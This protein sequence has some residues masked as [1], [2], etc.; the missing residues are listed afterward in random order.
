MEFKNKSVFRLM[1]F[2]TIQYFFWSFLQI[3]ANLVMET[4]LPEMR[5]LITP[6]LKGKMHERQKN[7]MLV[8]HE[9]KH[10]DYDNL[11]E[12]INKKLCIYF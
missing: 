5:D 1:H 4:L 11:F 7:W 3:L 8:Y 2:L 10:I 9:L 6:K 12:E